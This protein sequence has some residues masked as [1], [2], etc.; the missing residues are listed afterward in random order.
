MSMS[1]YYNIR[2]GSDAESIRAIAM[3]TR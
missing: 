1:G 2:E 3:E